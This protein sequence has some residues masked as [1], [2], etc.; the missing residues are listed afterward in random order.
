[1]GKSAS[2]GAAIKPKA[3][4]PPAVGELSAVNQE[5]LRRKAALNRL[6]GIGWEG[7]LESMRLGDP[8]QRP[9]DRR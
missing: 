9:N 5:R 2:T 6:W 7:D 4:E 1:M 3:P 8:D